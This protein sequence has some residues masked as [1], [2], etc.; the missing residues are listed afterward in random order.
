M[1][2]FSISSSALS[3]VQEQRNYPDGH[4]QV[5]HI[6]GHLQLMEFLNEWYQVEG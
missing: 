6:Y 4:E 1:V 3:S 2:G 5:T